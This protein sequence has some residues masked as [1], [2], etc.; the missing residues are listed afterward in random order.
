MF[1]I[2]YYIYFYSDDTS[3]GENAV[4]LLKLAWMTIPLGVLV[5]VAACLLIFWWQ[6]LNYSNP[7][8]QAIL[9]HGTWYLRFTCKALC[10]YIYWDVEIQ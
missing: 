6:D 9:I 10:I 8:A 1:C 5:S 4:K 2:T 3:G 7:Y